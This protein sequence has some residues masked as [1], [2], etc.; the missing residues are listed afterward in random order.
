MEQPEGAALNEVGPSP[1]IRPYV[2]ISEQPARR[3]RSFRYQ[4]EGRVGNI[5]GA[6]STPERKT[7]PAIQITGYR[8]PIKLVVSCVTENEP[9]WQHPHHVVIQDFPT[10]EAS[11]KELGV[12]I[13]TTS[14]ELCNEIR[15]E[16]LGIVCTK[17]EDRTKVLRRRQEVNIDPVAAGFD[18]IEDL[19]SISMH[20][21]RLCF[22][23]FLPDETGRCCLPLKPVISERIYDKKFRREVEERNE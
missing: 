9:Y 20:V 19:S 3:E 18:H 12:S 1:S 8:G 13:F 17:K 22:Q 23:V 21:V 5:P 10:N 4:A 14:I 11:N 6:N 2:I 16:K 7:Y 15:F